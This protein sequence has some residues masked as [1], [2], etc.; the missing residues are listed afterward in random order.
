MFGFNEKSSKLYQCVYTSK[1]EL[2]ALIR[3]NEVPHIIESHTKSFVFDKSK[4]AY[5]TLNDF[6]VGLDAL[7]LI[8]PKGGYISSEFYTFPN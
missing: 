4:N 5:V 2:T 7:V 8:I 6:K 1:G 3:A